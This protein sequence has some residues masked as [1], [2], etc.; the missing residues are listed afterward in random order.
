M[1]QNECVNPAPGLDD[2][3]C[4]SNTRPGSTVTDRQMSLL[5][6]HGRGRCAS[7]LPLRPFALQQPTGLTTVG[8]SLHPPGPCLVIKVSTSVTTVNPR[9][10]RAVRTVWEQCGE[11]ARMCTSVPSPLGAPDV[12]TLRVNPLHFRLSFATCCIRISVGIPANTT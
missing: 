3:T 2:G 5:Y 12:W 10:T 9:R 7:D 8:A 6:I 1:E 11:V 4:H